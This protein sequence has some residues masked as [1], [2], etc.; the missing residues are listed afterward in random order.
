[1]NVP[2]I[3]MLIWFGVA[4]IGAMLPT[5]DHHWKLAYWLIGTGIPLWIWFVV[6]N[7]IGFGLLV[8]LGAASVLRWPLRYL[9]RWVL[10]VT[11]L[12]RDDV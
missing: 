1:M 5:K 11:G 9:G 6:E 4:S 12:R 8:L 7:G 2:L 10:R 3:L